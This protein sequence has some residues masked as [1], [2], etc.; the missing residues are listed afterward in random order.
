MK[1]PSSGE[2]IPW[3][4]Y[5]FVADITVVVVVTGTVVVVVLVSVVVSSVAIVVVVVV[6]AGTY[7]FILDSQPV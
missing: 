5:S 2:T 7:S 3:N 4:P 1:F 6:S